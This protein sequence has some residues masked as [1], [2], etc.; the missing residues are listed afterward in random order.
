MNSFSQEGQPRQTES[1]DLTNMATGSIDSIM[2]EDEL[3]KENQTDMQT[4]DHTINHTFIKH[5]APVHLPT[6]QN[7][8]NEGLMQYIT[9]AFTEVCRKIDHLHYIVE[10]EDKENRLK[11]RGRDIEKRD[12]SR[13]NDSRMTRMRDSRI[14]STKDEIRDEIGKDNEKNQQKEQTEQN[15][16][17][18]GWL[19]RLKLLVYGKEEEEKEEEIDGCSGEYFTE[20]CGQ[21]LEDRLSS[22]EKAYE[23]TFRAEPAVEGSL[24]NVL[25]LVE[26]TAAR[27]YQEKYVEVFEA[28]TLEEKKKE[29]EIKYH[30]AR[31]DAAEEAVK[32]LTEQVSIYKARLK[33]RRKEIADIKSSFTMNASAETGLSKVATASSMQ[34]ARILLL[35]NK[36]DSIEQIYQEVKSGETGKLVS[37]L[38]EIESAIREIQQKGREIQEKI[39]KEKQEIGSQIKVLAREAETVQKDNMNLIKEIERKDVEIERLTK[40]TEKTV[41][42]KEAV[43][44]KQ[45]LMIKLLNSKIHR[46]KIPIPEEKDHAKKLPVEKVKTKTERELEERI[47]K[48]QH[49]LEKTN[50]PE[51]PIYK[52]YLKDLE[53]TKRRLNDFMKV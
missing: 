17:K 27:R 35:L 30:K 36:P 39:Q 11:G 38:L 28:A 34:I 37:S 50:N 25:G 42:E 12:R 51:D 48:I 43:I 22:E 41:E 3:F 8:K 16:Q 23:R 4:V 44:N 29:A 53:D 33:I 5:T 21:E 40:S 20:D 52:I 2:K 7:E 32:K 13:T 47:A 46:P 19:E 9:K 31:A 1:A 18:L 49:N 26:E 24:K 14:N 45:R 10:K 15:Q 6:G